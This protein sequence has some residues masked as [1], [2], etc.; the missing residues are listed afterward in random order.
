LCSRARWRNRGMGRGKTSRPYRP[1]LTTK[2]LLGCRTP[3]SHAFCGSKKLNQRFITNS[4]RPGSSPLFIVL[5][6]TLLPP[7]RN[8]NPSE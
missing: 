5:N 6:S 8:P 7:H 4:R 2:I 1:R 3:E